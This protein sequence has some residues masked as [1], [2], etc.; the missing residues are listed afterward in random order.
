MGISEDDVL[1][2]PEA[3]FR[4]WQYL[5]AREPFGE[6]RWDLLFARL[7]AFIANMIRSNDQDAVLFQTFIPKW[8]AITE[9][10]DRTAQLEVEYTNMLLWKQGYDRQRQL[11][12]VN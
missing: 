9:P 10:I 3:K 7:M 8:D 12:Q 4:G 2:M 1:N 11:E 6:R 5:E